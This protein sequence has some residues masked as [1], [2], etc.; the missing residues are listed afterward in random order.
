MNKYSDLRRSQSRSQL[1]S[2]NSLPR[3][4]TLND[5]T[6]WRFCLTDRV[7]DQAMHHQTL[8]SA[9][10][11]QFSLQDLRAQTAS[12]NR[13]SNYTEYEN[14][15]QVR[16]LPLERSSEV[17]RSKST[18][19]MRMVP[20]NLEFDYLITKLGNI[21]NNNHL[22]NRRLTLKEGST[23]PILLDKDASQYCKVNCRGKLCPMIVNI[24]RTV[25]R[26]VS[27]VSFKVPE[28]NETLC[29]EVHKRDSFQVND[30][31]LKFR[32]D[33]IYICFHALEESILNVNIYFGSMPL[34]L[35]LTKA[36]LNKMRSKIESPKNID[37]EED[38]A[39][40]LTEDSLDRMIHKNKHTSNVNFISRN[41]LMMNSWLEVKTTSFLVKRKLAQRR[42]EEVADKKDQIEQDKRIKSILY[43]KKKEIRQEEQRKANEMHMIQLNKER[44]EKM[45]L[46]LIYL[47]IGS[48]ALFKM[49]QS[50]K[51]KMLDKYKRN[52][53]ARKIQRNVRRWTGKLSANDIA[54]ER[55]SALLKNYR[56]YAGIAFK[57]V[58]H[59]QIFS[60]IRYTAKASVITYKF[61]KFYARVRSVQKAW[62]V[63]KN[64]KEKQ[65]NELLY[66]WMISIEKVQSQPPRS[67]KRKRIKEHFDRYII[68]LHIRNTVLNQFIQTR[69]QSYRL[70]FIDYVRNKPAIMI[71]NKDLKK[72][73]E[74]I[75]MFTDFK[76]QIRYIPTDEEIMEMIETAVKMKEEELKE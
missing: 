36:I 7:L 22:G 76:P 53:I 20:S 41:K 18:Q 72:H 70:K 67:K 68:P 4:N 29:D 10:D 28:P 66:K 11:S 63:C 15:R 12:T 74:V 73:R 54:I 49:L 59:I 23:T 33:Y 75:Q 17:K 65:W 60:C 34:K 16:K 32:T 24:S 71:L 26:V 35:P 51:N 14:L 31:G 52:T 21:C 62:R 9:S 45:W 5:T 8:R 48:E 27:Y 42:R 56:V 37:K 50:K 47:A 30:N 44:F 58:T 3:G 25:G 6:S 69:R 55:A 40:Q 39:I 38:A 19:S 13:L 46:S 1:R 64:A 43:L 2:A 61:A 57:C